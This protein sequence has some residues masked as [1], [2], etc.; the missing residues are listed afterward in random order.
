MSTAYN[1]NGRQNDPAIST[2]KLETV[3][4][5]WRSKG[6]ILS[7]PSTWELT[8]GYASVPEFDLTDQERQHVRA[9]LLP[10]LSTRDTKGRNPVDVAVQLVK[11]MVRLVAAKE[12]DGKE[13]SVEYLQKFIQGETGVST[14]NRNKTIRL[15]KALHDLGFVKTLKR[16]FKGQGATRYGLAG[17]LAE[18]LGDGERTGA[19]VLPDGDLD[20]MVEEIVVPFDV[21]EV[22]GSHSG[23]IIYCVSNPGSDQDFQ[24]VAHAL[25]LTNDPVF[26]E[27]LMKHCGRKKPVEQDRRVGVGEV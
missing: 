17:R 5:V 26:N 20:Q 21:Q 19:V 8:Y 27:L 18:V 16:G 25:R 11:S 6:L 22:E 15:I 23:S 9:Y 12:R 2:E 7:D 14:G 10:L 24:P 4:A 13:L 1:D 3:I